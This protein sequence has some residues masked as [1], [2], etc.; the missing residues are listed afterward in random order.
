MTDNT[1]NSA[2]LRQFAADNSGRR[3][4]DVDASLDLH[5]RAANHIDA[6][7]EHVN[8]LRQRVAAGETATPV[9]PAAPAVAAPTEDA[10]TSALMIL[11]H[12]QSTADQTIADAQT[13]ADRTVADANQVLA[14]AE[15]T[16]RE[17]DAMAQAKADTAL[18]QARVEAAGIIEAAE[19]RAAEVAAATAVAAERAVDAQRAY[20][21]KATSLRADA[22]GV[23]A[24][25]RSMESVAGEDL[26]PALTEQPFTSPVHRSE[27]AVV[28]EPIPPVPADP[29]P[30]AD[31]TQVESEAAAEVAAAAPVDI[32]APDQALDQPEAPAAQA[33][34]T[35]A[36]V[37][38]LAEAPVAQA[39]V[40]PAP[41][42][43]LLPPPPITVT[44]DSAL[45]PP[46]VVEAELPPPPA[47]ATNG[48]NLIDL[49]EAEL[50]AKLDGKSIDDELFDED[51]VIDITE[52]AEAGAKD[53]QFFSRD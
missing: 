4:I 36:P 18:A 30:V 32:P 19:A 2:E 17:A 43:D 16:R 35:P 38:G 48:T 23:V 51:V 20:M 52:D 28:T 13:A 22:E 31:T 14:D 27:A 9:Q 8:E 40:P 1:T 41:A 29:A 42:A 6:L 50:E 21:H 7:S 25:A 44:D 37:A 12:A 5:R 46:P 39:D 33:D 3:K 26:P 15:R 11:Q 47:V 10:S 24:L 49:T 45:P 34:L 53:F